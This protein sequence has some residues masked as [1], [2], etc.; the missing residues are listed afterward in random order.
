ME[1]VACSALGLKSSYQVSASVPARFKCIPW[2]GCATTAPSPVKTALTLT[3]A[4]A[5]PAVTFSLEGV[6]VC[7]DLLALQGTTY[8]LMD[9][10]V[11][12]NVPQGTITSEMVPVTTYRAGII[13]LW[14][15]IC[16]ATPHAQAITSLIAPTTVSPVP[17]VKD[18]IF[19]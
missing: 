12:Q 4:R 15:Q 11:I 3:L 17:P 10:D 5:A 18:S 14:E 7:L 1:P 13:T 6:H 8:W 2:V 9:L 16:S 19:H